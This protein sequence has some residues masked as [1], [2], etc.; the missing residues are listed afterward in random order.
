MKE[1]TL[2]K[3][4][5]YIA[6]LPGTSSI[7]VYYEFNTGNFLVYEDEPAPENHPGLFCAGQPQKF[8]NAINSAIFRSFEND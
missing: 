6:H 2:F 4:F 5:D 3:T 1:L 7:R 8:F